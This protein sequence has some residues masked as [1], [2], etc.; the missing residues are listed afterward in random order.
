MR[1]YLGAHHPT[2]LTKVSVPLF[3]SHRRLRERVSP[4][5]KASCSWALDSGGFTEL[6]MHGEWTVTPEEY[7]KA[8]RRYS[9]EIGRP[10]FAAPQDWMCEPWITAKTGLSVHEHQRRTVG[11]YLDLMAIDDTLAVCPVV[12]GWTLADYFRCV[13]M[14]DRAGVDLRALPVVGVGSVCRRQATAEIETV[15]RELHALGLSI[16]G[17]GVKTDGL[18][19]YGRY[20]LSADSM[21]WS[22][23]GRYL[24]G[25]APSHKTEANCMR[26]ALA[27]RDRVLVSARDNRVEQTRLF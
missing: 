12:Q 27:W 26:Y 5:P 6:S 20:V 9:D 17:F 23:G 10:D 8:V 21:A 4:F 18:S 25:C 22:R 24:P 16:H 2:W 7:V 13:D 3:V 11:N 14:Y 15:M 19:R 1:F